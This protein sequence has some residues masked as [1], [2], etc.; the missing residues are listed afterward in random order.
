VSDQ[1]FVISG[2]NKSGLG[3]GMAQGKKRMH[4]TLP[5]RVSARRV[6][7]PPLGAGGSEQ[8]AIRFPRHILD[9]VQEIVVERGN[10]TE[11]ATIIREL[12]AEALAARG[13]RK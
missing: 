8:V 5:G 10:V 3:L 9:A 12:V 11:R 13:R 1:F 7:R 4:V 6:G 2:F